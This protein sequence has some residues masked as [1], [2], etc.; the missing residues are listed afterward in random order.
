MLTPKIKNTRAIICTALL[1]RYNADPEFFHSHMVIEDEVWLNY[2]DPKSRFESM[3]GKH[4]G[5]RRRKMFKITRITTKPM[6]TVFKHSEC[7]LL[8][9]RYVTEWA[10]LCW[11]AFDAAG[12][13][14]KGAQ[15]QTL[16]FMGQTWGPPGSCRPQMGPM[17]APRTLLSGLCNKIMLPHTPTKL[18][19]S[20]CAIVHYH[21]HHIFWTWL[22]V[23]TS[24]FQNWQK[25]EG[26]EIC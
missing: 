1:T 17:L 13:H 22:P 10:M 11:F 4:A 18:P 21:T 3:G 24:F 20:L 16:K 25:V 8:A 5:F 19:C 15:G 9:Y 26:P 7:G 2:H 23:I 12:I 14:Q 6:T